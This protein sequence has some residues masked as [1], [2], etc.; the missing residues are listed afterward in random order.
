MK[1]RAQATLEARRAELS[2]RIMAS[3]SADAM[4]SFCALIACSFAWPPHSDGEPGEIEL[5]EQETRKF[6][7]ERA[8]MLARLESAGARWFALAQ[9]CLAEELP[10]QF[11]EEWKVIVDSLGLTVPDLIREAIVWALVDLKAA[12]DNATTSAGGVL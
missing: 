3:G 11:C 2:K 7:K 10:C 5:S 4:K 1:P 12:P 9:R 6:L 8:A